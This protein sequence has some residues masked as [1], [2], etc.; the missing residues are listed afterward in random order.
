MFRKRKAVKKRKNMWFRREIEEEKNSAALH[1]QAW[2]RMAL[3]KDRAKR[4][5]KHVVLQRELEA[6]VAR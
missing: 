1:I 3:A 6:R 4:R 2:F 5:K